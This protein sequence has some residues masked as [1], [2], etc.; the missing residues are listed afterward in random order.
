VVGSGGY[1][2]PDRKFYAGGPNSV[3]GFR[4]NGL[5]PRVYLDTPR[6]G[7]VGSDKPQRDTT[8]AGIG[9]TRMVVTSAE[10]RM[11]SPFFSQ[12]LRLAAFMDGGRVWTSARDTLVGESRFRFT[13]GVGLRVL[14][15]VGPIRLDA[16]Y[17]PYSDPVGPLIRFT[18]EGDPV[19]LDPAYDPGD[20]FRRR[21]VFY[22][23]VGQAF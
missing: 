22:I 20:R 3:R 10:L 9:G 5:G 1:I 6:P 8:V 19:T 15:P 11:P 2:P 14:T 17:N 7:S 12:N 21:F 23:A 18:E 4:R 13:P 16:A